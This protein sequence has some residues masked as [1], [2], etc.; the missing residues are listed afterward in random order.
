MK[1]KQSKDLHNFDSF[2]ED[3]FFLSGEL[4]KPYIQLAYYRKSISICEEEGYLSLLAMNLN[5]LG[6]FF[7]E[8]NSEECIDCYLKS[9][10]IFEDLEEKRIMVGI[11]RNLEKFSR[12]N[13]NIDKADE[14]AIKA[15]DLNDEIKDEAQGISD[16]K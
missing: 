6:T 14:L 5:N 10:D 15:R 1:D 12:K 7:R 3:T 11:V 2:T 4:D 13:N 8:R 16:L 9:Y